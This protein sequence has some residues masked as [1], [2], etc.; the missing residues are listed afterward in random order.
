MLSNEE[1]SF[2]KRVRLLNP[3]EFDQVFK[4]RMIKRGV[5]LTLHYSKNDFDNPRLGL[6]IAK[7]FFKKAVQRNAIKRILRE[8]FRVRK[9]ELSSNDYV[10]RAHKALPPMTL[11]ELK[12]VTKTDVLD[13]FNR[14]ER[15]D[16]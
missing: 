12:R 7:K 5:F 9:Q 13:L 14:I 1:S 11:T 10:F 4:K 2:S 6:V 16:K 8:E 15:N 3:S